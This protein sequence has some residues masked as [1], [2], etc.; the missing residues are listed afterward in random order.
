MTHEL[1]E[2]I[3]SFI[4]AKK[5]GA[6]CALVSL[7]YLNGSSYR[8]PGVRMLLTETGEMT[9]AVS[10]GCVEKEI[11]RQTI[12]VFK[13]NIPKL[14]VYDGRYRLGCE[15]QLYLLIEPF[16]P[17][18]EIIDAFNNSL[19]KRNSFYIHSYFK[20]EEGEQPNSGS[21]FSFETETWLPVFNTK[22]DTSYKVFKQLFKPSFRLVIIG[23]EHDAVALTA[24][25]SFLGWEV[26]VVANALNKQTI[27]NFPGAIDLIQTEPNFLNLNWVNKQAAIVFMTHSY[28]KDLQY[29]VALKETNPAYIGLLGPKDRREKILNAFIE[30]YPMVKDE[31]LDA[32]Y[33]PAG[34]NIGSETAQEIALSICAEILS[35]TRQKTPDFLK[36]KKL[37][38]HSNER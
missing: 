15:G 7:V 14:M 19:K 5:Q 8:K 33:G 2:I 12:A 13:S 1:K 16:N 38:I 10:G 18:E 34:L 29:L 17:S 36:N 27:A 3:S 23:A 22:I 28:A 11:Q 37:S 25:A 20:L 4:K 30:N 31:F 35:V 32:I 24:L 9:G 26:V 6:K 21:K